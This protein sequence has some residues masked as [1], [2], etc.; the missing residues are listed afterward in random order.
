MDSEVRITVIATGFGKQWGKGISS[1]DELRRLIR[2]SSEVLDVPSFLR[3]GQHFGGSHFDGSSQ[4]PQKVTA[5]PAK[6]SRQ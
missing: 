5:E 6:I 2:G 3:R 1:A 4:T